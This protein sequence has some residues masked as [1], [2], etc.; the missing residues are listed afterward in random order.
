VV[1][2]EPSDDVTTELG[3]RRDEGDFA[4]YARTRDPELRDRLIEANLGLAGYLSR[5]YANR[6]ESAD[7]LLQVASMALVKAV[8]RFDP[9]RDVT[10]S[11]FATR[12]ILGELKRHFRDRAWSVRPPRRLQE[13]CLEVT[14]HVE[15][16]TQSMGRS[17]K[18]SELAAACS[19]SE[20]DVIEALEAAQ[21]YRSVSLDQPGM[22]GTTLGL[23]IGSDDESFVDAES[24]AV[25]APHFEALAPRER[26]I[27]HL[28][29]IEG[30]T[31]SEI[32]KIVGL[33]QMQVSRV[34]SASLT[35]LRAAYQEQPS[36]SIGRAATSES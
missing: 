19:V 14:H 16:L 7:D 21:S 17:P 36:E 2:Q 15:A 24:R 28:R 12:T 30:L 13:L 6:G 26:K 31:Q 20:S 10:F 27:L 1:P 32:G 8:D 23:T 9:D 33:S 35:A 5:R 34:L 29:F 4:A 22:D 18:V 3:A 11:T 25:F